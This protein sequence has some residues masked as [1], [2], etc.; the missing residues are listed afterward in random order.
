MDKESARRILQ[1]YR[2]GSPDESDPEIQEALDFA[3]RDRELEKWLAEQV[4]FH[5]ALQA[6]FRSIP[7][8]LALEQRIL[9][10]IPG[11]KKL[12][13]WN[14]PSYWLAAAAIVF[15]VGFAAF[16]MLSPKPEE[17]FAGFRARMV[18]TALRQYSMDIETSNQAL[19]RDFLRQK[20][21]H[22]DYELPKALAN[23]PGEG[24]GVLS[25]Q[26]NKVA[27]VCLD[28]QKKAD[29]YVFVIARSALP[30]PPPQDKLSI[31]QVGRLK[32][33]S[34]THQDKSYVLAAPD[35]PGLWQELEEAFRTR[36]VP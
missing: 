13:R 19:I 17:R 27:M 1:L 11:P 18:R 5:R 36:P 33:A 6:K 26:G 25:W 7:V 14:Q 28:S 4:A 16:W 8:P 22:S 21:A 35:K 2:P 31:A 34:W 24:G 20:G 9:S 32:T 12:I 3:R 15:F 23:L 10:A 30:D 29:L